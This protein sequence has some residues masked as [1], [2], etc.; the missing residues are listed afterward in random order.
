MLS[1]CATREGGIMPWKNKQIPWF[2]KQLRTT[3]RP[4]FDYWNLLKIC[5]WTPHVTQSATVTV[6]VTMMAWSHLEDHSIWE[7][8]QPWPWPWQWPWMSH[9]ED[10]SIQERLQPPAWAPCD[11]LHRRADSLCEVDQTTAV[12][13][14]KL[15]VC[16]CV[17]VCV[18]QGLFAYM[19]SHV[20]K[21][22]FST[23]ELIVSLC[24]IDQTTAVFR[25]KLHVFVCVC[26]CVCVHNGLS[27]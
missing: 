7:S 25:N 17:C 2:A 5:K 27:V 3:K 11:V 23:A 24:E 12:L 14:K 10:H 9:L 4:V 18:Y 15:H 8:H 26:V 20:H 13:R 6:T 1:P 16:V 21:H 22:I 19:Y